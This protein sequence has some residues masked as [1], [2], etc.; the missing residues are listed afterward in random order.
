MASD[1]G[2]KQSQSNCEHGTAFPQSM[3][4]RARH[5]W[6]SKGRRTAALLLICKIN[7]GELRRE[8]TASR[9]ASVGT[10]GLRSTK[11]TK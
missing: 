3:H 10:L 5:L 2:R 7:G 11:A 8:A 4:S 1:S 9:L 6:Y